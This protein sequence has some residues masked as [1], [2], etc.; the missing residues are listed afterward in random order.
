ML[1]EIKSAVIDHGF[2]ILEEYSI[3]TKG[4]RHGG[5]V[6]DGKDDYYTI[7]VNKNGTYRIE[8]SDC[9]HEE[10]ASLDRIKEILINI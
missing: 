8:T 5:I 3:G 10:K 2:I 6:I 4:Y 9:I 7:K 1:E